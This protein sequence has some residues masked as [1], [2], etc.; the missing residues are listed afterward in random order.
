MLKSLMAC[1]PSTTP[2]SWPRS[3]AVALLLLILLVGVS[4]AQAQRDIEILSKADAAQVFGMTQRQWQDNLDAVVRA[5]V[6]V[7][8]GN[9]LTVKTPDGV[10]TTLPVYSR[11][12]ARPSRLEVTVVMDAT[13]TAHMTDARVM[14]LIRHVRT[15]MQPEYSADV[16]AE[17]IASGGI[18]FY[19]AVSRDGRR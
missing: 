9:A 19:F 13:R 14:D 18:T 8:T 15:D 11:M 4:P 10:V 17:R 12:D 2:S 3:A 5:G 6:G 16:R 7:R 1:H